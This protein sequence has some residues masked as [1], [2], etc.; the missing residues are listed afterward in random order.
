MMLRFF[1]GAV[2]S[3]KVVAT[4]VAYHSLHCRLYHVSLTSHIHLVTFE[5]T[6]TEYVLF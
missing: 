5:L 6:D 4:I 2:R 3:L 1:P